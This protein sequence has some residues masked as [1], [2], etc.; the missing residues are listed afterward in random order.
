MALRLRRGTDAERQSITPAEGELI[1]TTD[2]KTL[3]IGDSDGT[4]GGTLVTGSGGVS[5][6]DLLLDVNSTTFVNDGVLSYSNGFWSGTL[7]PLAKLADVEL[8]SL[9][10]N[11]I[12]MWSQSAGTWS[13]SFVSLSQLADVNL[14]A[15]AEG[16]ILA[17]DLGTSQWISSNGDSLIGLDQLSDVDLGSVTDGDFLG[18]DTQLGQWTATTFNAAGLVLGNRY[19]IGLSADDESPLVDSA[20]KIHYGSFYGE[21]YSDSG[22]LLINSNTGIASTSAGDTLIDFTT[23]QFTGTLTGDV[24]GDVTGN[25]FGS[26]SSLLVDGVNSELTG[27]VTGLVTGDVSTSFLEVS[28]DN[29]IADQAAIVSFNGISGTYIPFVE[30]NSTAGTIV[31]PVDQIAGAGV[32]GYRINTTISGTNKTIT[33]LISTLAPDADTSTVNPKAITQLAVGGN[34]SLSFFNFNGNGIFSV[35]TAIKTG[36]FVDATDRDAA[37]ITPEAGT[38]VLTGTTFQGYNGTNW[39]DLN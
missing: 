4:Q 33:A 22:L 3:W 23:G 12:L 35:P 24:D 20:T 8:T 11:Q 32:G 21:L 17:Y 19:N 31:A 27:L 29:T 14:G 6:L 1:Y 13:G 16:N 2:E 37:V 39:V 15:V 18:Y 5:R 25:V 26:D 10:D 38:I 9:A 28:K 36:V 7:L 34:N 30:V